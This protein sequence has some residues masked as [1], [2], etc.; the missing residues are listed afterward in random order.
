MCLHVSSLPGVF[1]MMRDG[2]PVKKCSAIFFAEDREQNWAQ[3][4]V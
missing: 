1:V 4:V 3:E 2:I